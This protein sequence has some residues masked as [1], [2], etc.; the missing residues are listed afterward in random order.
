MPNGLLRFRADNKTKHADSGATFFDNFD[1]F[2][3]YDP[4]QGF[5]HYVPREMAA[6]LV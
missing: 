4:A 1:Y 5:V 6:Q 2:T 3:G